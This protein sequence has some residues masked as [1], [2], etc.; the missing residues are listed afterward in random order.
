MCRIKE[1]R[2]HS[3]G[4]KIRSRSLVTIPSNWH[5]A[6]W[7]Y[8][9]PAGAVLAEFSDKQRFLKR[10]SAL[11]T[12]L[13]ASEISQGQR[14]VKMSV[15][16]ITHQHRKRGPSWQNPTPVSHVSSLCLHVE[17]RFEALRARHAADHDIGA[18]ASCSLT[19]ASAVAGT[20]SAQPSSTLTRPT[21]HV[22]VFRTVREC[23]RGGALIRLFH[24][25]RPFYSLHSLHTRHSLHSCHSLHSPC[26]LPVIPV[27]YKGSGEWGEWRERL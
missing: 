15:V 24:S 6:L 3:S 11:Q 21:S 10:G 13:M 25:L 20:N 5:Q 9:A 22:P 26:T 16:C 2:Q 19:A 8:C 12:V 4:Y 7:R 14:C 27:V 1:I 23:R 18:I 17:T